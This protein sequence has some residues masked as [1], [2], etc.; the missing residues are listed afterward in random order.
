MQIQSPH[1]A[2]GDTFLRMPLILVGCP[3]AAYSTI[4]I[5]AS[6]TKGALHLTSVDEPATPHDTMRHWIVDRATVGDVSVRY[7]TPPRPVSLAT[8]NGP[9]Y[10]LR[11]QS[12][13]MMGA[14]Y[15]FIADVATTLTYNITLRWDLSHMPAGSRGVWSLGEGTQHTVAPAEILARSYY[16][17]GIVHS[18]PKAGDSKFTFYWM[19]L[20]PPDVKTTAMQ[21][22]AVHS[23]LAKFFHDE[24]SSYRIFIRSNPY[25]GFGGTALAHSFMYGYSE[26]GG[27]D[28]SRVRTYIAHE[29]VHNWPSLDS[30]EYSDTAWYAEGT[31]D[32]FSAVLPLRA[33]IISSADFLSLI[34]DHAQ[35][36]YTSPYRGKS[37]K[38]AAAKAWIDDAAE[39]VP[40]A[41]GFMY[42]AFV[43]AEIRAKSN[44]QRSVD[45][46]V[47]ELTD[48]QRHGEK[49]GL[50]DWLNL[51]E[52]ELGPEGRQ[53]YEAMVAGKT[54]APSVNSFG[55]CFHPEPVELPR[56][57][58]GFDPMRLAIVS[59]LLGDS[60]AAKAGV[61][62]GD[63][64]VSMTAK[65]V[66][67]KTAGEMMEMKVIRA[68]QPLTFNF[69]PY[70]PPQPGWQWVMS[71]GAR[72]GSCKID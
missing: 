10:D 31:A 13:G 26:K 42:L 22:Q 41:R 27:T 19:G 34:N 11:A 48:R 56:Y 60:P 55:P 29:M 1:L 63:L 2:A 54:E 8:R 62:E 36:Y 57:D 53:Q 68:G 65:R 32:Y 59:N 45:T 14:G 38:E 44:G 16:A 39:K 24:Q 52:K 12:D 18:E 40:Y 15:Y 21:L 9:L 61:K 33:G 67:E 47:V 49:V 30:D 64:I 17:A 58:P 69:S 3:S 25:P 46:L 23:Y 4:D 35:V 20:A 50:R 71:D 51:V 43:D 5:H 6:D 28:P 37:N 72:S 66:L 7:G 70:G